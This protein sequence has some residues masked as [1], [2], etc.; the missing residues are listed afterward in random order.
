MIQK[1]K[2][3]HD[4]FTRKVLKCTYSSTGITSSSPV[5]VVTMFLCVNITPFGVPVEPLVYISIAKSLGEGGS[6]L[7]T[8]RISRYSIFLHR[9]FAYSLEQ[10]LKNF[11]TKVNL[12]NYATDLQGSFYMLWSHS[13][14]SI[15]GDKKNII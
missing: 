11:V 10:F 7:E 8:A 1:T 14:R 3:K 15:L 5:V 6:G 2:E 12:E 9:I 13:A 4:K